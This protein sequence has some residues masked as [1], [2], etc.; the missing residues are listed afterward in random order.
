MHDKV[1][2]G[3]TRE[4]LEDTKTRC[5]QFI[6]QRRSSAIMVAALIGATESLMRE[7]SSLTFD[8][9]FAAA[10]AALGTNLGRHTVAIQLN[11]RENGVG[12]VDIG[13]EITDMACSDY[14][15]LVTTRMNKLFIMTL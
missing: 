14:G 6:A 5:P 12:I 2:I 8:I 4:E 10:I 3:L 15:A 13:E 11:N 1:A 9:T 7:L